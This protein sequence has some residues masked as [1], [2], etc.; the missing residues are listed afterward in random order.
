MS[1]Q[2]LQKYQQ[3]MKNAIVELRQLRGQVQQMEQ[4][5]HEPIAVIG[6]GCRFPMAANV[7]AY[8]QLL[9]D[10]VDA[11]GEVPPDRWPIDDYFDPDPTTAGKMASRYGGFVGDL[12]QFDPHF[13]GISPRETVTLDPQQ[14]LLL[15]VAWE[16]LE[17]AGLA[18][19]QMPRQTGV[20]TG[21]C[22]TDYAHLVRMQGLEN[23]DAYYA[24]GSSLGPASG[25]LSF[26]LGFQGPSFIVDTACSSS[27]VATHLAI[28]SLRLGESDVALACGV[29]RLILPHNTITF[30]QGRML[31]PDGRCK[32]FDARADGF[33][34]GEGCGVL[35]LK[36]LSDAERDGDTIWA[37]LRGSAVNQ[38]G[39]TSGLTVPNGPSQ[40]AVIRAALADARVN[41]ADLTYIEAHGTGTAL[42]DP[43][44]M[45]ALG[46]VFE[47]RE[48]PLLVGS[49][50]TNLGHL[51]AAAGVA[52]LIKTILALKH[53][54]LPPSLHFETPT[55]QIAWDEL[56]VEVVSTRRDWPTEKR[57]AG[58]SGFG[59]SGTNAHVVLA[60]APE[61]KVAQSVERSVELLTLS[62]KSADALTELTASYEAFLQG[63]S[64][65]FSNICHT[66]TAGRTHFPHRLVL[67]AT[68][69]S[70]AAHKLARVRLGIDQEGVYHS[71]GGKPRIAFLFTG[72][73]GQYV[74]MGR[75]LYRTQPVFRAAIDECAEIV[76]D[77]FDVPLLTLLHKDDRV[78]ETEFTQVATFAIE[79]ALAQMWQSWGVQPAAVMGHSLGE[80][81]AACVAGV[82]SLRDGLWFVRERGRLMAQTADGTMTAVFAD[83]QTVRD[84][85]RPFPTVSVAVINGDSAVTISG[86]TP[87]VHAAMQAF[88]ER[89]IRVKRLNISIGSHSALMEPVLPEFERVARSI[90]YHTPQI[91]LVSNLTGGV[92][93]D[94]LMRPAHWVRHLREGVRFADGIQQMQA[95]GVD[96]FIETGPSPMLLKVGKRALNNAGVWL[97]SIKAGAEWETLLDSVAHLYAQGATLDWQAIAGERRRNVLLP[98]YPFQRERYWPDMLPAHKPTATHLHP[99]LQRKVATPRKAIFYESELGAA[100]AYLH[101][102][103]VFGEA[104]MPAAGFLEMALAAGRDQF[105]AATVCDVS[106]EQPL[107]LG[108]ETRVQLVWEW[109]GQNSAEIEI[110][111]HNSD[112]WTRHANGR[113]VRDAE[114]LQTERLTV[115]T[116]G[117]ESAETHYATFQ[118]HGIEYGDTF[119][120]MQTVWHNGDHAIVQLQPTVRTERYHAH[121][122]VVDA[123]FQLTGVLLGGN[124][125]PIGCDE[126]R[127]GA[128]EPRWC[129]AYIRAHT[130]QTATLDLTFYDEAK[131]PVIQVTGLQLKQADAS[132]FGGRPAW[133]DWL[134][135]VEWRPVVRWGDGSADFPPITHL[136]T[137]AS[138]LSAAVIA[139]YHQKIAQLEKASV[140]Y[141]VTAL[142]QL[143]A[144]FT[145]GARLATA[146]QLGVVARYDG[147]FGRMLT[148]LAD[149]SLLSA[150]DG[151]VIKNPLQLN[152]QLSAPL[153]DGA[154]GTLLHR[155]GE[156]LADVLRGDV[157]PLQ[158]LFPNGDT[159]TTAAIYADSVEAQLV[160]H[161]AQETLRQLVASQ[162]AGQGLRILEVGAGTGGTTNKLLP[163][164]DPER[165]R[166]IFSDLSPLFL[167]KAQDRFA[168]YPFIDYRLF[169]L[170]QAP[171]EQGFDGSYDVIIAANVVHATRD[172]A[173]SVEHL[174]QLLAP[175]GVLLL[176]EGTV[177]QRWIDLTFGL[178]EGWWRF[179]DSA[180]RPDHPLL[181]VD[182]WRTALVESGLSATALKPS[183]TVAQTVLIAQKEGMTQSA[184]EAV[185][186]IVEAQDALD[187]ERVCGDLL[188]K[189][190]T[191]LAVP[192][193]SPQRH[194]TPPQLAI[195][196]TG[197]TDG[198]SPIAAAAW[199]LG[200]V[201]GMEHPELRCLQIDVDSLADVEAVV[202]RELRAHPNG[203]QIALRNG[204]RLQ[205]ILTRA[206]TPP[207][208]APV[209][210]SDV[211]YLIT[212]GWGGLGL[213]TADLLVEHGAR[214]LILVGRSAPDQSAQTKIAAL[215]RQGATI[216]LA[217]AD[218][219]D[220]DTLAAIIEAIDPATPLRGIVHAAGTLR[221]GLLRDQTWAN[222]ETVLNAKAVG[223]WSLHTLTEHLA[224]D[225][226]WLY[227]SAASLLGSAGQANHVAANAFMDALAHQRRAHGLAGLA[228]NWG[229]WSE[230]GSAVESAA[231]LDALG[232]GAIRTT[233]GREVMAR[234]FNVT[235]PQ[236]GVVNVDW[237]RFAGDE[238]YF[239]AFSA[240][241][242][243]TAQTD[244]SAQFLSTLAAAPH[245]EREGLLQ[246]FIR[247][248]VG[249]VL[250]WKGRTVALQQ[251]FFELGMDSLLAL[252]LRSQLQTALDCQ[253][254]ATLTFKYPTV[255]ELVEHL[256]ETA[257][258]DYFQSADVPAAVEPSAELDELDFDDALAQLADKLGVEL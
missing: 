93:T 109:D 80:F 220:R 256:A 29:N 242:T 146:R 197:A 194:P 178:T 105:G 254:S 115:P 13:F 213:V 12:D 169:D 123:G 219:A 139:T 54:E 233:V 59:F 149:A 10:G 86:A 113:V 191:L 232:L 186:H 117:G 246:T 252:E 205:P 49:A 69:K 240:E 100:T 77:W 154:E 258:S 107:R 23:L 120:A 170:E 152:G 130:E 173:Q 3:L 17:N 174:H 48:Q 5:R 26:L 121:P 145:V 127:V 87:A 122:V 71:S 131:Q 118:A 249:Q 31:A 253:L 251:G 215:R 137:G 163:L 135:A 62:A 45:H 190:Q 237:E 201:V 81:V 223:A 85:L 136:Q 95:L 142:Q 41:S 247:E 200:R 75:D 236:I 221:D 224:L 192:Q 58:V 39:R 42:G 60:A 104:I 6:V 161:A 257:L 47:K 14:R 18:P 46:A 187:F 204:Q 63:S 245:H 158:L 238:G 235:E 40:Q 119:R 207:T 180:L 129:Q 24:T 98:N 22:G 230:V 196:T 4:E 132:A 162:P 106:I 144:T 243:P 32:A 214:H 36:R 133:A 202:Q 38:D 55:P 231:R 179:A 229:V 147:L 248:R 114:F 67:T 128:G 56:P 37:L 140:G 216:T 189:V 76:R 126:M 141:I 159:T 134:Y 218:V 34:R 156:R 20:F 125:L 244:T 176:L 52:G 8:W 227:S 239:G 90:T 203:G 94:E 157:D 72:Q 74:G 195:V 225:F 61:Q 68:S 112:D 92:V 43:I 15:E 1:E 183:G 124:Y 64:A 193:G 211:T 226:F 57:L 172:L 91:P 19:D 210:R 166:Y 101:D 11:I 30:S 165:T 53:G 51:E 175:S 103:R 167:T 82:F 198:T 171:R 70:D 16:A 111:S 148:I 168:D 182:A 65:E 102:H 33:V 78:H 84:V 209:I 83:E 89:G 234:L 110:Y 250:G 73:G 241:T 155:C 2:Q 143:G 50:K 108:E 25:R 44:E 217:Q 21:I 97:P 66:A 79:Y 138:P 208:T 164:L 151:R 212:G 255:A 177:R 28:N 160:N 116:D 27:L 228:I 99:L 222:F 7:A 181:D 153:P 88:E 199:G 96:T 188:T 35:V 184:T 206:A 185:V 9:R 150:D